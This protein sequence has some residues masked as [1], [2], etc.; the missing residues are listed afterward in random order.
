MCECDNDSRMRTPKTTKEDASK[1]SVH[2]GTGCVVFS[3]KKGYCEAVEAHT[4][5]QTRCKMHLGPTLDPPKVVK[6]YISISR[7][8]RMWTEVFFLG[9]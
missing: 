7:P 8:Q 4:H 6:P 5:T 9:V 3:Y 2:L 1:A